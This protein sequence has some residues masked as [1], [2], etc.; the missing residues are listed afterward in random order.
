MHAHFVGS[1][2]LDSTEE[3]FSEVGRLLGPH[4]KRIPDGEPG[5][6]RGWITYQYPMLRASPYLAPT[7]N[8]AVGFPRLRI[9]DGIKPEEVH[10]GELGYA[11]E[12]FVSYDQLKQARARGDLP[13]TV[14][15]QVSLPTPFAVIAAFAERDQAKAIETPYEQAMVRE[16]ERICRTIPHH[17]LSFQWDVCLEMLIFDGHHP[18]IKSFPGM[19]KVFAAEFTRLAA[20]IPDDIELGFHLCYGDM[21]AKHSV[22]PVDATK[23]VELANLISD[24]VQRPIAFMH[25]PV[26]IERLDDAFYAPLSQLRLKPGCE[27][28]LGLVHAQDG[29]EGTLQRIAL[30]KRHVDAFGIGTECGI[31]R[32]RTPELVHDFLKTYAGAIAAQRTSA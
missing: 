26:P 16:I 12:A 5:S 31:S 1:I 9:A 17:D 7:E 6:R 25:L 21:D 2:G 15:L 30:A 29:V 14:K 3:V 19:E 27:L 28:F 13:D 32:C 10:F 22:E 8:T 4:L 11:R 24:S 20:A 23:M 18:A